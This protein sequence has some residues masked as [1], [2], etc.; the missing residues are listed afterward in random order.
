MPCSIVYGHSLF[1]SS[2]VSLHH[3]PYKDGVTFLPFH[4]RYIVLCSCTN[5]HQN[6][7]NS[8]LL[9]QHMYVYC[10]LSHDCM[11]FFK[12]N[13]GVGCL[14]NKIIASKHVAV[15]KQTVGI[16]CRVVYFLVLLELL[17]GGQ[18]ALWKQQA[19]CVT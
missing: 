18:L 4:Q 15:I 8:A 12:R 16:N 1:R 10:N 7:Y 19:W 3:T 11:F 13:F 9:V 6:L 14:K 17:T 5:R 2:H